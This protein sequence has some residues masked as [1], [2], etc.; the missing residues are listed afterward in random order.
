MSR[1]FKMRLTLKTSRLHNASRIKTGL[2]TSTLQDFK[3]QDLQMRLNPEDSRRTGFI[4]SRHFKLQDFRKPQ[5]QLKTLQISSPGRFKTSRNMGLKDVSRT[6]PQGQDSRLFKLSQ[7]LKKCGVSGLR[8]QDAFDHSRSLQDAPRANRLQSQH[9][10][11]SR[12]KH[13]QCLKIQARVKKLKSFKTS[14][15]RKTPGGFKTPQTRDGRFKTRFRL[16]HSRR[17]NFTAPQDASP[18]IKL[19]NLKTLQVRG[20]DSERF[21]PVQDLKT[22]TGDYRRLKPWFKPARLQDARRRFQFKTP[23]ALETPQD[24]ETPDGP[25]TAQTAEDR[26][27]S[28]RL[29]NLRP[30]GALKTQ[31]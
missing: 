8:T 13:S 12:F 27:S 2:K 10:S 9:A 4:T 24:L 6:R 25:Q 7:G 18:R 3:L 22:Q 19:Q 28:S 1:H 11:R 31:T 5:G 17:I 20:Q 26:Y 14:P 23:Q 15:N 30:Q 16:Q 21:K 29:K